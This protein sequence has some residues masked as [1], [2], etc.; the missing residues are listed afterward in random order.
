MMPF[1]NEITSFLEHLTVER[2]FSSH[3]IDAYRHDLKLFG[4]HCTQHGIENLLQINLD[5]VSTFAHYLSTKHSYRSSSAAR[6][7]AAVR[8]FLRFLVNEG[9]LKSDPSS[10]VER[11]KQWHRLPHVLSQK[12]AHLLTQ[13]P[14]RDSILENNGDLSI[15]TSKLPGKAK[16]TRWRNLSIRDSAIL[17]LLYATGMR[18]SELCNLP[19]DGLNMDLGMVRATGKGNKTRLVPVGRAA[20][21]AVR[22]YLVRVRPNLSGTRD[23]N[24]LFLSKGHRPMA[25]EDVWALVKKHGRRAGLTGKCSPHT[26]RHSFATH[27]LEGGANLRAV[28]EMLGHADITTTELYTHVDAKRLLTIH[29]KF[30]PRGSE[31]S[32]RQSTQVGTPAI[33]SAGH[34]TALGGTGG[35]P[36]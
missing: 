34:I 3:T 5:I 12:D 11:P 15:G 30:H 19:L 35:P 23:G 21:D 24:R 31:M 33:L 36:V 26:L 10:C 9:N 25:R 16:R 32:R 27:L 17:E 29:Q 28:Q 13:A 2:G 6:S 4:I 1:T 20:I 18:V 7:L 22:K 8:S 14:Q